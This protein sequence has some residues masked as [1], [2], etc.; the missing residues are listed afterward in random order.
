[1]NIQYQAT[2]VIY[3][4]QSEL[5]PTKEDLKNAYDWAEDL[6][7]KEIDFDDQNYIL[8]DVPQEFKGPLYWMAYDNGHSA[9]ENEVA[10]ILRRLVNDLLPA[11]TAYGIRMKKEQ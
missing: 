11:I 6:E 4:I 9:G 3:N 2:S 1:M 8:R 5:F 10:C 7:I